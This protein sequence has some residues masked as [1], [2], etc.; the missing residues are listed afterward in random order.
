[1]P[2]KATRLI[3]TERQ[4][5]ILRDMTVSRS[6]PQ[7]L[8]VR[9]EM[10]LLAFE[11]QRNGMIASRLDYERHAVG[12]WRRRWKAGFEKLIHAECVGRPGELRRT[13][14]QV[15]SDNQRPGRPCKFD[16]DHVAMIIAVACE[17]P[18][19]SQRPVTHW[20]ASEL[21][22]EVIKR[23]IVPSISARQVGRFLKDGG[24][25]A[26]PQSLLAQFER[27]GHAGIQ[28][29][30]AGSM[31]HLPEGTGTSEKGGNSYG[32]RR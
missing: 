3:I 2:R 10:I 23:G 30:G 9:A 16:A 25:S 7:G 13:I 12:I 18:E 6:C 31:R 1:M 19:K 5:E 24:T 15:L 17:P 29:S 32:L 14:E 28:A 26:P 27:E 11:R 21:A 8:A 22:D 4:Q 20:T